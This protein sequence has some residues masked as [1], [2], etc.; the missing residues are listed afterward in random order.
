MIKKTFFLTVLSLFIFSI[1]GPASADDSRFDDVVK[2]ATDKLRTERISRQSPGSSQERDSSYDDSRFRSGDNVREYSS[3]TSA[4]GSSPNAGRIDRLEQMLLNLSEEN[5]MLRE[6]VEKLESTGTAA[7][8]DDGELEI[9]DLKDLERD[10]ELLKKVEE[11]SEK[12]K[13]LIE[14]VEAETDETLHSLSKFVDISGYADAEFHF[15]DKDDANSGFRIH[16]LS[17]FFSKDIQEKWKFFSEIEFEDAP[18][19]QA[20]DST[21]TAADWKIG[22][23]KLFVEQMYIEYQPLIGLDLQFGRFLTPAGIWNVY[24]YPPYVP[25][26]TRPMFVRKIFPQVSDGLQVRKTFTKGGVRLNTHA[27]VSNGTGNPG[28]T[29][30][31]ENKG[32]GAMVNLSPGIL[33]TFDIGLSYYGERT[34]AGDRNDS[35]GAHLKVSAKGLTLQTEVALRQHDMKD[36]T[37]DYKD[38]GAYGQ[39]TFDKGKWTLAGRYDWYDMMRGTQNSDAYV[40]TGAVNYHLYHNVIGKIEYDYYKFDDHT[41]DD[42]FDV[43]TSIVIAIGDL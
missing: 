16:H 22:Q 4:S 21:M 18:F 24:H 13:E 11:E 32:V 3:S 15:T 19:Y 2:S 42:Y 10:K 8:E 17:L 9:E 7:T 43:I 1:A 34:N 39:L 33:D 6:R 12:L 38:I 25:T 23:G 31:N 26:Q 37:K 20:N 35:G 28:S 36:G 41:V 5:R 27:Y 40:F 30:F 29:D 14:I